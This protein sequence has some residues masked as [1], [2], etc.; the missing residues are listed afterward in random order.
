MKN[1]LCLPHS[2]AVVERVFASKSAENKA[3]KQVVNRLV[4]RLAARKKNL[5][6]QLL[7]HLPDHSI[8]FEADEERN[9][10]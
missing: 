3:K 2:S 10:W 7:L 9:V 8:A 4:V 5:D 6:G 1:I